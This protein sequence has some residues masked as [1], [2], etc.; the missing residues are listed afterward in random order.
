MNLK[1]AFTPML[2]I[3]YP[4]VLILTPH[5]EVGLIQCFSTRAAAADFKWP[6]TT[7]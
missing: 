3:D 6:A 1:D 7:S 4:R 5:V 2:Q